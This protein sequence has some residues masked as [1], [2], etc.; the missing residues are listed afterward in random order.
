MEYLDIE[1]KD[2]IFFLN[3]SMTKSSKARSLSNQA[4]DGM[5]IVKINNILDLDKNMHLLDKITIDI[6]SITKIDTVGLAV[7]MSWFRCAKENKLE[8]LFRNTNDKIN[9]ACRLYG[10]ANILPLN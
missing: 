8:I 3:G 2:G 10:L 1:L 6:N 7:F 4:L 9:Y 5:N